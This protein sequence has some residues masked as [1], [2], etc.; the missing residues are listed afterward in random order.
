[1]WIVTPG[2]RTA[3]LICKDKAAAP[4]LGGMESLKGADI[5]LCPHFMPLACNQWHLSVADV[6]EE[7]FV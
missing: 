3:F 7:E 6:W 5:P 4:P 1:M 2:E